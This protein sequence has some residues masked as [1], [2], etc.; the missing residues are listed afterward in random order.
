MMLYRAT[1]VALVEYYL[2]LQVPDCHDL[3]MIPVD[4]VFG[5]QIR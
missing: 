4:S 1:A 3:S 5:T 2:L